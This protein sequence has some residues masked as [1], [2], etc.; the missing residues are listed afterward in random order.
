MANPDVWGPPMWR[1]LHSLAERL[2]K[3]TNM[4]LITDEFRAWTNFLKAVEHVIP[5]AKCRGHYKRWRLAHRIENFMNNSSATIRGEARLWLWGLHKEVNEERGVP[6]L[7][8]ADLPA[9]YEKRTS[10]TITRDSEDCTTVFK[11]A[12]QQ[13]LITGDALR[14]F[15]YT[16]SIL[17]TLTG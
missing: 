13:S 3:Q 10:S 5:C 12:V 15:K 8:I 11:N 4:I 17:R 14:N 7:P 1:L 2:G 6:N 9:I 16:L